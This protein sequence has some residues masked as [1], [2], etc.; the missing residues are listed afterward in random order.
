MAE[1]SSWRY[2]LEYR[3]V[4]IVAAA[5]RALPQW[6]SPALTRGLSTAPT[7]VP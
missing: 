4:A 1:L 5:V 2:G 3:A 6:A 7:P